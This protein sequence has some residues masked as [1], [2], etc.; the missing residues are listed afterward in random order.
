M[1]LRLVAKRNPTQPF[2]SNLAA[3]KEERD[4]EMKHGAVPGEK[5]NASGK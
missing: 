3:R 5:K 1:L 2:G 4:N